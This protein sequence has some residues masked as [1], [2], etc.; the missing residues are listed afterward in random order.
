M[1]LSFQGSPDLLNLL[2]QN[3]IVILQQVVLPMFVLGAAFS[4]LMVILSEWVG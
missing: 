2:R 1:F 3:S 4:L